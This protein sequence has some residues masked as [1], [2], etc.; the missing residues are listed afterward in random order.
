MSQGVR[1]VQKSAQLF[2][3]E[4]ISCNKKVAQVE[5][6]FF[7]F[8]GREVEIWKSGNLEVENWEIA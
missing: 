5:I 6:T 4:V 7:L 8:E 1:I 3:A 2:Y